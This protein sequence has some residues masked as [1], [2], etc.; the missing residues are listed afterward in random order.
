MKKKISATDCT[1]MF[2]DR[3]QSLT[4]KELGIELK[5]F[6]VGTAPETPSFLVNQDELKQ[7]IIEKFCTFFDTTKAQGL[8]II[9]LKSNYGNGKSHFIRTIYTFL[10]EYENVI[11]RKISLKQEET[12]LKKKILESISQK[13]LKACAAFFINSVQDDAFSDEQAAILIA[14]EEKY[15]ID[16]TL[17]RLLYEAAKSD[18]ITSQVQAMAILKGNYLPDY[19]KTFGIKKQE[20]NSEFY[21]NVIVLV[22][23]YLREIDY[24][25]VIVFDEYE[26]VF[27]WKNEK[28]RKNLY[29]D[30]KHFTDHIATFGNMFFIFAESDSVDNQSE[31]SDDPAFK[32]RKA[33]MTYQ[34]ADI[35]SETEVEK[36]FQK[37]RKRYETYYEVSFEAEIDTIIRLVYEDPMIKEKTNY[38]G[39]T[40]AIMRVLDQFRNSSYKETIEKKNKDIINKSSNPAQTEK[41]SESAQ[42]KYTKWKRATSISKKTML[43]EIIEEMIS[44]SDETILSKSK[45]Q[46][47]YVTQAGESQCKYFVV[48]TENPNERDFER[49]LNTLNSDILNKDEKIF[50]LYPAFEGYIALN[51]RV[52]SIF[53]NDSTVNEAFQITYGNDTKET[54]VET[55]ISLLDVRSNNA[56]D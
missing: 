45:K 35:S 8:E 24:Y 23:K 21:N 9:F 13:V 27:S 38:R 40:Q 26:H 17:A 32:S 55:Y 16:A 48:A 18:N 39:Y 19:L 51:N 31:S 49:R 37:I 33:N 12:D 3:F 10:T 28:F 42:E 43:C 44:A 4:M 47:I 30:I 56:K 22:S 15:S 29:A 41:N 36:L 46:G 25:L 34:I 20:L 5:H 52:T 2:D 53:Y 11:T 54:N 50:I 1:A 7:K 6:S 14:V